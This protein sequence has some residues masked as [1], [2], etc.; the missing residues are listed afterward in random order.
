MASDEVGGR[1]PGAG[2]QDEH[3][4]Q[5]VAVVDVERQ[6]LEYANRNIIRNRNYECV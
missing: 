1:E 2:V 6:V 5:L 3:G 4:C